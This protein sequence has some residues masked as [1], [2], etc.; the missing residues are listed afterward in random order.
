MYSCNLMC[1][2]DFVMFCFVELRLACVAAV[3]FPFQ[4]DE[5]A[6]E[7]AHPRWTKDWGE[8]GGG[9]REGGRGTGWP[10]PL[11]LLLIFLT[12]SLFRSLRVSFWKRLR[13]RLS[14]DVFCFLV[15]VL[16]F[17]W[18]SCVLLRFA[19]FC[20]VLVVVV[21]F[22]VLF[23]CVVFWCDVFVCVVLWTAFGIVLLCWMFFLG[24]IVLCRQQDHRLTCAQLLKQLRGQK[25][26][27]I[28]QILRSFLSCIQVRPEYTNY[29]YLPFFPALVDFVG[30]LLLWYWQENN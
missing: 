9:E 16:C 19:L 29:N 2:T 30:R 21:L 4:A 7:E 1:C 28:S 3:S 14:W 10:H 27:H 26:L 12:P 6:N 5:Q 20:C 8:G 23:C 25:S 17:V 13:S 11:P 24:C 22:C 18:L 15:A